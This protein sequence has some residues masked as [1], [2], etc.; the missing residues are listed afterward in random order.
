MSF[1][2]YRVTLLLMNV[3]LYFTYYVDPATVRLNY[4]LLSTTG[5]TNAMTNVG[6][7]RMAT[8]STPY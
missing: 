7:R 2:A 5:T 4:A 6:V 8:S 3:Y 1:L